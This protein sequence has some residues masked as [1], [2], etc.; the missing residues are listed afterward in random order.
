LSD[1]WLDGTDPL[2]VLRFLLRSRTRWLICWLIALGAGGFVAEEAWTGFDQPKRADGN[3]GHATID[4]GGQWLMG[5]T[6]VEGQGR[7]LYDRNYLRPIAHEHYPAADGEPQ[8][9]TGDAEALLSW[10][11]GVDHGEAPTVVASFLGP[12]AASNALDETVLLTSSQSTWTEERLDYV[13]APRIGGALYPPIHALAYAPLSLLS[14]R[15]AY[16]VMQGFIL[17]LVYFAGW[18]IQRLTQG[19]VWWPVASVFVMMFPGFSGCIA[20]GQNGLFT[21]VLLL[22]GWWQLMRGRDALAGFYWGLL[23]F[24]PVWAAAFFLVPLLT[25][26]WRMAASMAVT[27]L[28]QIALTLPVVGWQAWRDWLEVGQMA[29]KEYTRQE[30]WI[31][32]SRDLLGIPR[33]WLVVYEELLAKRLVWEGENAAEH[34]EDHPLPALLGWGLWT[35]VLG[36]TL[37]V[38]WRRREQRKALTGPPAAFVLSAAIFSC[39][40]FLYYDF[41]VAGLPVLLMFTEP[42]RYVELLFWQRPRW[43]RCRRSPS[44]EGEAK[45]LSTKEWLMAAMPPLILV[46]IVVVP[47]I[48]CIRDPSYHFPPSDTFTLLFLWAWCGYRMLRPGEEAAPSS[49]QAPRSMKEVGLNGT[50]HAAQFAELGGDVGSTHERLA[51][52]HG[53]DASRL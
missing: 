10:L 16:R 26:R 15:I 23:A 37:F 12:L 5:R 40:H 13:T 24:K 51:D 50:V 7:H 39:Y 35:T 49:L 2:R 32:L 34:P 14:P 46:V 30:N 9:A 41:I 27:G 3:S 42:R 1:F 11:A 38:L 33:R 17:A 43:L 4:F 18:V 22:V 6:I 53:A 19:R 25:A 44:G 28:T 47:A 48:S 45:P 36:F 52:Q 29:A 20:L 8:S 31:F 21:F